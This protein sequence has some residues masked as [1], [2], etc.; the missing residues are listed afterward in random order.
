MPIVFHASSGTQ[1]ARLKLTLAGLLLSAVTGLAWA[2]EP[3]NL[4]DLQAQLINYHDYGGYD[5]DLGAVAAEA[6]AYL[7]ERAKKVTKPALVLD[8]DETALSNWPKIIANQFAY[9]PSGACDQ[10]PKGPCGEVAWETR[11]SAEPIHAVLDLFRAAKAD[12]VAVFFITG[13]D[14]GLRQATEKN[15]RAGG[16]EGWEELV[17]RPEG[18]STPSAANYKAPARKE[19][20]E[21]GFHIIANVGDQPSDLAGGYAERAFLLPDPFYRIP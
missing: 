10:L 21:H 13:R 2:A 17:M 16:Y 9:F 11:A 19:I 5:R 4:G 6:K 18:S 15:L 14:N 7:H 20:E 1:P 3:A 8:I 12:G